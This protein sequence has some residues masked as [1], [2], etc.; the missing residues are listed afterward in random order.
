V[1]VK[2][3]PQPDSISA[4]VASFPDLKAAVDMAISVIQ[5]GV[6][7]ARV[8]LLDEI[9]MRGVNAYAKLSHPETPTLFFEFHGSSAATREQIE[10]VKSL[11]DDF[12]VTRLEW[13]GT[14]GTT[15]SMPALRSAR[16]RGRW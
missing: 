7:I 5:A 4:V 3:H 2:L 14:P 6:P 9:M 11:S 15:R 1:T 13:A 12:G 16:V 10:I 8:E